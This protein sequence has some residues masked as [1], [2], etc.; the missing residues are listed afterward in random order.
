[1]P[2]PKALSPEQI[3]L[4]RGLPPSGTSINGCKHFEDIEVR[5]TIRATGLAYEVTQYPDDRPPSQPAFCR[6]PAAD[7]LLATLDAAVA[8]EREAA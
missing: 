8:A 5:A 2:D 6:T 3:E 1:M 4:L 7:T